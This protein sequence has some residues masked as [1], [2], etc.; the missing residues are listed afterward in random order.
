MR[1]GALLFTSVALLLALSAG[2]ALA[3]TLV[4]TGIPDNLEWY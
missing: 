2:M 3:A 1:R 4:G